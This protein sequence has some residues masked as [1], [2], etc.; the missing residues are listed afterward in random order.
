MRPNSERVE[1]YFQRRAEHFDSLYDS[2]HPFQYWINRLLRR[3][4]YQRVLLTLREME[5]VRDF[6]VLDVGCG[7]GRNSVLFAQ[8]GAS[9]VLGVDVSERMIQLAQAHAARAGVADRCQ[10]VHG[11]FHSCAFAEKFDFVVAL[12]L[13]DYLEDPRVTLERMVAL[14]GYRVIASFPET[15]LLR[16]PQRKLRYALR[17]CPVYFYRRPQLEALAAG[18]GFPRFRLEPYASAGLLLVGEQDAARAAVAVPEAHA[19]LAR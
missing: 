13:F 8:A 11:D 12:G 18:A 9:R 15:S 14:A 17:G 6:T 4:L 3:G 2:E 1:S 19:E 7:P 16:A 10:F 5:P